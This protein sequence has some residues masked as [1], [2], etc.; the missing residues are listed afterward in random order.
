MQ[1]ELQLPIASGTLLA[2]RYEIGA[3]LGAGGMGWVFSARDMRL[4]GTSVALKFLYPHLVTDASALSRFRNEVLVARKL[5]HPNIVR[6]YTL[7]TDQEH[8]YLVM[9]YVDGRSLRE[10]LD[11][12]YQ[13]G[14]PAEQAVEL[15]INIAIAMHH[16]HALG[17]IHRDLKPDNVMISRSGEVKVS[18]FGLAATLRRQGQRTR[19]GQ[20]LGTPYYM[21]P[22]QFRGDTLDTRAD[23]YAF[24]ILLYELL[25]GTVPFTDESL[26]GLARKHEQEEVTIPAA[27]RVAAPEALWEIIRYATQKRP[28]DRFRS[29]AE[30]VGELELL[31]NPP[32]EIVLTTPQ[33]PPAEIQ[34]GPPPYQLR[35]I[36]NRRTACLA[37]LS[38]LLLLINLSRNYPSSRMLLAIPLLRLEQGLGVR[39]D[40]LRSILAINVDFNSRSLSEELLRGVFTTAARLR[41]GDDPNAERNRTATGE[42][43]LHVAIARSNMRALRLLLDCDANPNL[44]AHDGRSPLHAAVAGHDIESAMLLLNASA[45]PDIVAANGNTP[46]LLAAQTNDIPMALLLLRAGA[47]PLRRDGSGW[48]TLRHAAAHGEL[49]LL[50]AALAYVPDDTEIDSATLLQSTPPEKQNEL[51]LLLQKHLSGRRK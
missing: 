45:L 30:V 12:T 39:L 31:C 28:D 6:T 42:Y 15:S 2:Q 8:A 5:I 49:R 13:A 35:R 27:R 37:V 17:I 22:E 25:L 33:T 38:L 19:S 14:M 34:E 4:D 41:T 29:F 20:L 10:L 16:S 26:Y 7:E 48:S 24:G 3:A 43:P 32:R 40:T 9:E 18:D 1:P 44:T 11:S 47:D 46:L 21:A 50:E 23:I 36:L 51:G